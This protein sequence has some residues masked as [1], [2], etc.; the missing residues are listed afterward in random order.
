MA[1]AHT[2]QLLR[3]LLWPRV[4]CLLRLWPVQAAAD[5]E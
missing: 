1:S 5:R 3:E 2:L 4:V